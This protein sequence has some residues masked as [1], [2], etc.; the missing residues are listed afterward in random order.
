MMREPAIQRMVN[1]VKNTDT[2]VQ[3]TGYV[4]DIVEND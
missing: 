4:K 2:Q 1:D 3:V